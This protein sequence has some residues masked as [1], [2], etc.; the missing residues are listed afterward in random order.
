MEVHVTVGGHDVERSGVF[1]GKLNHV[2]GRIP[3]S[4]NIAWHHAWLKSEGFKNFVPLR[5]G[6]GGGV[7]NGQG[8]ASE[9][10]KQ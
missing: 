10:F 7:F 6:N 3:A 4:R 9:L 2:I 8:N 1:G 5:K